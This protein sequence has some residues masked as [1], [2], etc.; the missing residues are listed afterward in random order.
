MPHDHD[1]WGHQPCDGCHND[2]VLINT[3]YIF[4]IV[5]WLAVL[6]FVQYNPQSVIEAIVIGIPIALFLIAIYNAGAVTPYTESIIYRN[7]SISNIVILIFPI[8]VWATAKVDQNKTFLTLVILATGFAVV[9]LFDIWID[10]KYL[11]MIKSLRS[12]C[13]TISIALTLLALIHYYQD[14]LKSKKKVIKDDDDQAV[15]SSL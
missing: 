11:C 7:S 12:I 1:E 5:L 14:R 8:L 6:F 4:G 15:I 3:S 13:Q 9:S 10:E 2:P